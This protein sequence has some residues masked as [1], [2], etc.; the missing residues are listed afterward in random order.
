[1]KFLL[2]FILAAAPKF[3][4]SFWCD[5]VVVCITD[6]INYEVPEGFPPLHGG[7]WHKIIYE[8]KENENQRNE[9]PAHRVLG[10]RPEGGLRS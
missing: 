1:M 7:A 3:E 8:M 4:V 10:T 6:S 2:V 5:E 9:R